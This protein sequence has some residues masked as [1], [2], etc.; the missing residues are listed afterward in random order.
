KETTMTA[1]VTSA[2]RSRA[3]TGSTDPIELL[4]RSAWV[5]IVRGILSILFGAAAF[6]VPGAALAG[7]VALFGAY[8]FLAGVL[9]VYAAVTLASKHQAWLGMLFEGIL[10]IAAGIIAYRAPGLTAVTLLYLFAA[11]AI[12]RGVLEIATAYALRQLVPGE[13]AI[14]VSGV[15]SIALGCLLFAYPEPGLLAW[16][17]AIGFYAL[18]YGGLVTGLGA[19][20]RKLGTAEE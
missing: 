9:A 16:V 15:L 7:L 12:L 17:W 4:R 18:L 10:G 19:R 14:A 3:A 1:P 5:P 11:W 20:L 8:A 2:A 6:V 13:W